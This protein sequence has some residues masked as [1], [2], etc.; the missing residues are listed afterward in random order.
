VAVTAH[1]SNDVVASP[2]F[3]RHHWL[4]PI[5]R[6]SE[7]APDLDLDFATLRQKMVRE[8]LI[9]RGIR[10]DRV[11]DAFR[12]VPRE[13]FVPEEL[14]AQ[15]Y[16]DRPL[17][18]G[19]GQTISQ[20]YIVALSLQELALEGREVVLEVGTGSGYQAALL[21]ELAGL[22]VTIERHVPL[23]DRARQRLRAL[24]YENVRV[25]VRDGSKG[26][27]R[28]GPFN[29][30]VAAAAA[31]DVPPALL[32]QLANGGRLV[33]PIEDEEGQQTLYRFTREGYDI[34]REALTQV[35]F[36][37]LIGRYGF[38]PEER[39]IQW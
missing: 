13:L 14:R 38:R 7:E 10:V 30:I 8:Q 6:G 1:L 9:A 21:A 24:G 18:I 39:P 28:A 12:K 22:V 34:R 15:A 32:E 2:A 29:A 37:P 11:L 19:L 33:M 35:R 16:E 26:Y 23:A 36:V 20:P 17:A 27:A 5:H 3:P 25:I 4:G 31:P